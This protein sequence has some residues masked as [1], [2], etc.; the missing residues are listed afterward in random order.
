MQSALDVETKGY[1]F[2]ETAGLGHE[3]TPC[4]CWQ[5]LKKNG[6]KWDFYGAFTISFLV[7]QPSLHVFAF[8]SLILTVDFCACEISLFRIKDYYTTG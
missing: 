4:D 5:A 8:H 6:T 2:N 3:I 1:V 7:Y